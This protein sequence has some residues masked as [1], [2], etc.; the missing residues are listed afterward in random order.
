[1]TN[2][3]RIRPATVDDAAAISKVWEAIVAERVYSA[4]DRA[5]TPQEQASYIAGL[6]ERESIFVAEEVGRRIVGFQT[7]DLWSKFMSSVAHVGQLGTFVLREARSH[8][9]GARLA[10]ATFGFARNAGY[11]KLVI[12]VRAS[13]RGAQAFYKRQGFRECGR[14][15]RQVKINGA[16][17]DEILMEIAL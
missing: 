12:Y 2:Q 9:I 6:D 15:A 7:L 13:N 4:V 5:F 16:Y 10:K 11:E 17:D 1:M 14:L 8:G 3:M